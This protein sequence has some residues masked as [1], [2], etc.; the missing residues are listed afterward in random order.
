MRNALCILK[1][2][3]HLAI[4]NNLFLAVAFLIAVPFV[5]GT[6]NLDAVR[7]AECLEQFVALIGI[8]LIVPIAVPEQSKS[9]WE[10]IAVRRISAWL[11]LL[12]RILMAILILIILTSFFAGSMILK[13]C[14][15]PYISYVTGTVVTEMV[16]GSVGLFV[17]V[18]CNSVVA[19][20]LV[21]MG[22]FLLNFLGNVSSESFFY[23]FSMGTENY[24]IKM[25]LLGFSILIIA[26]TLFY[27]RQKKY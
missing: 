24:G 11:V 7:S 27:E 13:Q 1:A 26:I 18:L 14:T 17:A 25:W 21:S 3:F 8:F 4:Q 12:V 15:F 16:L 5:R 6:E 10:L 22:F 20:Y 9:I 2:N 19:G 23:L